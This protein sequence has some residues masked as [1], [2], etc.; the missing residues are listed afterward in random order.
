MK[1]YD[2]YENEKEMNNHL[3]YWSNACGELHHH[4][5]YDLTNILE[6]PEELQRA[7]KELWEEGNGCLEYLV[8]YDGKYYI[9]LISEFDD[10]FAN[11]NGLSM[12]ELYERAKFNALKLYEKE[13]FLNTFLIIGKETGF[14]ECHEICFLVPATESKNMYDE[15][16]KE[17]Y[18]NIWEIDKNQ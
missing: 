4:G 11:D 14:G 8:E 12:D 7:Y 6:L 16:E 3:K 18:M 15:I 1:N 5:E 2:I 17:I 10:T 13:L 9:A